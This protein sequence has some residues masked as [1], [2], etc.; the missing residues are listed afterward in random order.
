MSS[1]SNELLDEIEDFL[2]KDLLNE[3]ISLTSKNK[4]QILI[5]KIASRKQT[6]NNKKLEGSTHVSS[7]PL[8]SLPTSV[9]TQNDSLSNSSNI[10]PLYEQLEVKSITETDKSQKCLENANN[11]KEGYYDGFTKCKVASE[12]FVQ[13]QNVL[14]IFGIKSKWSRKFGCIKNLDLL[15]Y[16]KDGIGSPYL[17]MPLNAYN[18][19]LKPFEDTSMLVCLRLRGDPQEQ[20]KFYVEEKWTKDWQAALNRDFASTDD[21]FTK[22]PPL[23][24]RPDDESSDVIEEDQASIEFIEKCG[25]VE[26]LGENGWSPKI[27]FLHPKQLQIFSIGKKGRCEQ[28]IALKGCHVTEK[29]DVDAFEIFKGEARLLTLKAP[30]AS[31]NSNWMTVLRKE[32][33]LDEDD[34]YYITVEDARK[35]FKR[36][37]SLKHNNALIR[38]PV[39]K[40]ETALRQRSQTDPSEKDASSGSKLNEIDRVDTDK[41]GVKKSLDDVRKLSLIRKRDDLD[42][43]IELLRVKKKELSKYH[44]EA[45]LM[46][47]SQ[48]RNKVE[49]AIKQTKR[50]I[51]SVKEERYSVNHQL[52]SIICLKDSSFMIQETDEDED[53]KENNSTM[54]LTSDTHKMEN[55]S[56][57]N[58]QNIYEMFEE[59]LQK[60]DVVSDTSYENIEKK[61][62]AELIPKGKVSSSLK[63]FEN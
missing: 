11:D 60:D 26:V 2:L 56:N 30:S 9:I 41:L 61:V 59:N 15:C 3:D 18:I 49:N 53:I 36:S 4:L 31:E 43:L 5:K 45:V 7:L 42:Q 6:L 46:Q 38:G 12:I 37:T 48:A 33:E 27:C 25:P 23:P 40:S 8:P 55:E 20:F 29:Q 24:A 35:C 21:H 1:K 32:I 47:S 39:M 50:D 63:K 13:R 34:P 19:E 51:S 16:Q 17:D 58:F 28:Q 62:V 57:A 54:K 52:Q 10:S 44:D 14:N 22:P